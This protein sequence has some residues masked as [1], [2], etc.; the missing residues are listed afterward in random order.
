VRVCLV[1][2]WMWWLLV[3]RLP[4]GEFVRTGSPEF[5]GEGPGQLSGL[6]RRG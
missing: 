2:P 1:L 3:V 5:Y 6:Y 4:L